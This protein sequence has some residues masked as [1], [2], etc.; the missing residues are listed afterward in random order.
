MD[1]KKL[2]MILALS[3]PIMAQEAEAKES[4]GKKVVRTIQ[5][6]EWSKSK[7]AHQ[8][9]HKK[10]GGMKRG[11]M[12]RGDM[13]RRMAMAKRKKMQKKR[14]WR[15]A[16]RVVVIGGVAYYVGLQQGKKHRKDGRGM[17]RRM[18]DKK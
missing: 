15:S 18:G 1:M 6:A 2:L 13:N 3:L 14:F 8:R 4:V 7:S 5:D 9:D 17:K 10:N 16:V 12:K 11:D